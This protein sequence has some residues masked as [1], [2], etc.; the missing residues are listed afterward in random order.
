MSKLTSKERGKLP[1]KDFGEPGQKKYPMPGKSHARDAK[2]RAAEMKNKGKLSAAAKKKID[3]KA[4]RV[5][6][7]RGD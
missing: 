7:K 1:K 6:G 2:A 4:N 5:L 3:T